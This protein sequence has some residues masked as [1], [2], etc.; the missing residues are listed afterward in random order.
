MQDLTKRTD[1]RDSKSTPYTSTS[2]PQSTRMQSDEEWK[3]EA[4]MNEWEMDANER[5]REMD[6]NEWEMERHL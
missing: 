5:E 4:D 6:M 2:S 3:W 1:T